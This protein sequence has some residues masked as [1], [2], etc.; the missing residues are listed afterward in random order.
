MKQ[1]IALIV[2]FAAAIS[3]S[4]AEPL[5]TTIET[6]SDDYVVTDKEVYKEL[7]K[8]ETMLIEANAK[9][10]VMMGESVTEAPVTEDSLII[11]FNEAT[12]E[13]LRMLDGIGEAKA[14]AIQVHLASNL[15][16]SSWDDLLTR[17][18]GVG[19]ATKLDIVSMEPDIIVSFEYKP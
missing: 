17:G 11:Y 19:P 9:L 2:I 3:L 14:N 18:V 13:E 10:D 16:V 7:Y 12:K 5:P 1:L 6:K 8:L 15:R 4:M